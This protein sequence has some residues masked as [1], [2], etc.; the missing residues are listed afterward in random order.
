SF[1]GKLKC[2]WL[3]GTRFKTR[4]EA[5]AAVFEYV[6]V[7]YNRQRIHATNDYLTPEEY[8]NRA[9]RKVKVA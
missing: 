1:W 3:Y 6:E 5:H 7:F 4:E 9:N 8:Y 2:E